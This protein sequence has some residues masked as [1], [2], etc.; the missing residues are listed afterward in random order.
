VLND[1]TG[2]LGAIGSQLDVRGSLAVALIARAISMISARS[3]LA[4]WL[5]RG[6]S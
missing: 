4:G 5:L 6:R 2:A 1:A 3:E